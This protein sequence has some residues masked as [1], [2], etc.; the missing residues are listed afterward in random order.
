MLPHVSQ[1]QTPPPHW[2]EL[3]CCNVSH[4]S[5]P[6]LLFREGSAAA[7]CPVT[8]SEPHASSIKKGVADLVVQLDSRLPK[9][10]ALDKCCN[11]H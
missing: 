3:R 4:G 7:T 9:T 6:S 10:H 11:N 5:K 8:L 1:L 2:E